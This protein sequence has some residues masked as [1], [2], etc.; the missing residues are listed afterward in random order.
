VCC[1]TATGRKPYSATL[2]PHGLSLPPPPHAGLWRRRRQSPPR[3][4]PSPRQT[5]RREAPTSPLAGAAPTGGAA[6]V[7]ADALVPR[8]RGINPPFVGGTQIGGPAMGKCPTPAGNLELASCPIEHPDML[9]FHESYTMARVLYPC[10][11]SS[12]WSHV[13]SK[14]ARDACLVPKKILRYSLLKLLS[15]VRYDFTPRGG[16]ERWPRVLSLLR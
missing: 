2:P 12:E 6:Y 16:S 15:S 4:L 3:A 7:P 5:P 10:L 1:A 13:P 11:R 14:S 9:R 8:G